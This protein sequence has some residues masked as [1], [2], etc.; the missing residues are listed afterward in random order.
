MA[1]IDSDVFVFADGNGGHVCDLGS[2]PNV[3]ETDVLCVNSNTVV[4]MPSGFTAAESAVANQ[5]AY[6]FTRK[7]AGGEG[8]TVTITTS[9]NH[10]TFVGWTRWSAL[11]A[12][13]TSTSTQANTSIGV[14]TPA[15]N[16]GAL[17]TTG[18]LVVAFGALHSIGGTANQT[19]PVWSTG[20]TGLLNAAQGTGATGVRGLVGYKENAGTAAE[21]PQVSWSGDGCFNRYML[22][23]SFT[24]VAAPPVAGTLAATLPALTASVAGIESIPGVLAATLPALRAALAGGPPGGAVVTRP[25][26]GIVQRP[27]TGT[28]TRP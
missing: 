11:D 6:I 22:A 20:Y 28:V 12:V 24:V 16:T 8:S 5:G 14:A 10:N 23:V 27:F 25:N 26:L 13:D 7:A 1:P 15:H 2:A 17:A 18:Q 3:G 4:S 21:T 19:S 9:G